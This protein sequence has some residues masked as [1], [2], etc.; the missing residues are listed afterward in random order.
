[1]SDDSF[2]AKYSFIKTKDKKGE[3]LDI[4]ISVPPLPQQAFISKEK[5]ESFLKLFWTEQLDKSKAFYFEGDYNLNLGQLY[6][7]ATLQNMLGPVYFLGTILMYKKYSRGQIIKTNPL[8]LNLKARVKGILKTLLFPVIPI[9]FLN[10]MLINIQIER[11]VKYQSEDLLGINNPDDKGYE[12][13]AN[14][15][16]NYQNSFNR[17]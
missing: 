10:N 4:S 16:Y 1:M 14:F 6:S 5:D 15:Q 8:I 11:T 2:L 12:E 3:Y 7:V 9:M 17:M 13:Y